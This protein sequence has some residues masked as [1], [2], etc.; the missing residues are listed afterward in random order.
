LYLSVTRIAGG[1]T[2]DDK[3]IELSDRNKANVSVRE[4]LDKLRQP[5]EDADD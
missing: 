3:L 2:A 4:F 1:R 5:L